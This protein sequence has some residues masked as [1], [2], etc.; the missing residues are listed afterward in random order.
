MHLIDLTH[1]FTA[2]MPAYHSDTVPQLKQKVYFEKEGF[3]DYEMTTGMHIGTH[4]DGPMHMIPSARKL[5]EMPIDKFVGNG[6]LIDARGKDVIDETVLCAVEILQES[7]VLFMTGWSEKFGAPEYYTNFPRM[8]RACVDVLIDREVKMVGM[9]TPSPDDAPFPIHTLFLEKEILLIENLAHLD[10]LVGAHAFE[11]YA[12][13]VKFET[14]S[15]LARV[16]ARIL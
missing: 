10:L 14:D 11:I 6:V 3:V 9:D 1:A 5:S 16:I 12:L 7:I 8:T 15:A 13:P 2:R 4:I